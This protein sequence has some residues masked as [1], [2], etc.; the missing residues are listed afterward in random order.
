MFKGCSC[1]RILGVVNNTLICNLTLVQLVING[2]YPAPNQIVLCLNS[3][4][5]LCF[6]LLIYI[7]IGLSFQSFF[8]LSSFAL[9]CRLPI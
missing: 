4:M 9:K 1:Q 3:I 2:D 7:Y 8:S 6:V 5:V